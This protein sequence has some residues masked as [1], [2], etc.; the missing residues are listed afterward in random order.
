MPS[1]DLVVKTPLARST[2]VQQLEAMFDVPAENVSQLEWHGEVP[3]DAKPWN[4]GLIVGP[5]GCGKSVIMNDL[6][7]AGRVHKWGNDSSVIDGFDASMSIND[8]TKICQAVGFNTIPSWLRPYR[9]LSVGEQFRVNLARSLSEDDDPIIVDEFTS[10]VDRQVAKIGSHAVQKY[11]RRNNRQFVG[12]SCHYDVVDWLQPDWT[13]EPATMTFTWRH[14]QHR[15]KMDGRISQVNYGYWKE[16]SRFHYLTKTLHRASR[17][18][19]LFVDGIPATF[20]GVLHRPHPRVRDIM[21]LSR[22]VTL[23]DYQ[24]MGL[25]MILADAL[26]SLYKAVGKRFHM[27]PAHPSF[28][29]SYSHSDQWVLIRKPGQFI[30]FGERS[31]LRSQGKPPV[32]RPCA[33]FCY[34]GK[35]MDETLAKDILSTKV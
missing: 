24:G 7:S 6:F 14:L 32:G 34:T 17:C 27:Y 30:P 22:I 23:P 4:V 13:L 29:R 16:F 33:V 20:A 2:R 19:A 18:F 11:V 15:P 1:V 21:G 5:S 12:A 10:V 3:L 35:A 28:I 26:G 9:V 8:V 31:T 25:A